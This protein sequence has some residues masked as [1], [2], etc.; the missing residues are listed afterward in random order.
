M[1]QKGLIPALLECKCPRCREG[2]IFPHG[3]Y[4]LKKFTVMNQEC[5]VCNL[6]YEREPG[7]FYGAMFVSYAL[8]VGIFLV[9]VFCLYFFVG[10]PELETY[11]ITVGLV[12]ALLYPLT[13]RY[14]RVLFLN[15]FS[16]VHYD[17]AKQSK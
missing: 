5:P 1:S 4:D 7:F 11:I 6:R 3:A 16:G 8:S 17:P 13:L 14:S 2:K 12:S 10:D 15:I 9:T